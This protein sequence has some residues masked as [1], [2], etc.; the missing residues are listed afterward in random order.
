MSDREER[1]EKDYRLPF[2]FERG[3][4]KARDE[5]DILSHRINPRRRSRNG[6]N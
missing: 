5:R 6:S 4:P 1:E 3:N 2:N